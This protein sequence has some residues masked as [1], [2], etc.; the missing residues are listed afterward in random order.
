MADYEIM[1]PD[2]ATMQQIIDTCGLRRGDGF[3]SQKVRFSFF[4]YGEKAG[5]PGTYAILRWIAPSVQL[6]AFP[7]TGVT[8]PAGATA[9]TIGSNYSHVFFG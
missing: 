6:L 7:P 8:L 1:A 5:F 3:T 9:T 2:D 4:V